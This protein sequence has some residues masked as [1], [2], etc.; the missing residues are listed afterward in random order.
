M[1][2]ILYMII[3]EV[4]LLYILG[5]SLQDMLL[6]EP[7]YNNYKTNHHPQDFPGY[8]AYQENIL[9]ISMSALFATLP[10][11]ILCLVSMDVRREKTPPPRPPFIV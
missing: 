4:V 1:K 7:S 9:W 2:G 10:W 11:I 8:I 6:H 3:Y 5:C